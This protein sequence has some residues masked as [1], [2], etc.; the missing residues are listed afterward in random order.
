MDKEDYNKLNE[1]RSIEF[2][3]IEIDWNNNGGIPIDQLPNQ[4]E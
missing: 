3:N 4:F 2:D 1:F